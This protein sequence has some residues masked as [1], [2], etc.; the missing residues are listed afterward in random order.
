MKIKK[1]EKDRVYEIFELKDNEYYFIE[2]YGDKIKMGRNI[3][4]HS[5]KFWLHVIYT[6]FFK[7]GMEVFVYPPL[8]RLDYFPWER[9]KALSE[10]KEVFEALK[11][12][13]EVE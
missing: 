4:E 13:R 12:L 7:E 5:E 10:I 6:T 2:H 1:I 8:K 9:E 11:K 3:R